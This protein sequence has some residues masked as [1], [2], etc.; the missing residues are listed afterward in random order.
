M[1]KNQTTKFSKIITALR[2]ADVT[3]KESIT[4]AGSVSDS[5]AKVYRS[6]TDSVAWLE[7]FTKEV[8][9]AAIKPKEVKLMQ[10][11]IGKLGTQRKMLSLDDKAKPTQRVRLMKG[12][13]TLYSEGLC[14]QA[15]LDSKAYLWVVDGITAKAPK[16][17]K[18]KLQAIVNDFNIESLEKLQAI[19]NE[20]EFN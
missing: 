8:A 18:E 9:N 20:L 15:Q 4:T 5:I 11:N 1:N 3:N 12:N 2:N 10:N 6:G 16:T 17:A 13:K 7:Y 14:T 19:I